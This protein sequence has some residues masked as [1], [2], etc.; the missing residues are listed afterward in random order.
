MRKNAWLLGFVLIMMLV[1]GACGGSAPEAP[2]STDLFVVVGNSAYSFTGNGNGDG[3][4]LDKFSKEN[5]VGI[6]VQVA[7][8]R[9]IR[10][11]RDKM[12]AGL[13]GAPDVLIVDDSLDIDGLQKIKMI[14]SHKVGAPI[15]SDVADSLGLQGNT[16][17]Y[18][19]FVSMV[20]ANNLSVVASSAMAGSASRE[21]FFSTMAWCA[22]MD[23][24][25]LTADI[26][27]MDY[28]QA[29]GKDVFDYIKSTNGANEALDLVYN[30]AISGEA[31]GSNTIIAFD[32][33]LLGAN[34]LNAKLANAGK[35]VFK[36]FYFREATAQ[37]NM[38]VGTR[39]FG[40]N[41]TKSLAADKLIE[42]MTSDSSQEAINLAGFTEGSAVLVRHNDTAFNAEWGVASNPANVQIVNAPISAVAGNALEVYRDYYKRMK[43]VKLPLDVSPSMFQN[44]LDVNV[45]GVSTQVLRIQALDMAMLKITNSGWLTEKKI[46]P[47]LKDRFDYYFFSTMYSGLVAQ[48]TGPETDVAGARL[49]YF[50]GPSTGNWNFDSY[51]Q[52]AYTELNGFQSNGTHIFDAATDMLNQIIAEYDPNVDY[53]IV[54]L[55]DGENDPVN[56]LQAD[57]FYNQWNSF[58][59]KNNVT[60]IGIQFGGDENSIAANCPFGCSSI[61]KAYTQQFGGDTYFGNNDA[62]LVEAFKR[63]IGR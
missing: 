51:G 16:I 41:E 9:D 58:Y 20:K 36:F 56:G 40:E 35:P 52:K 21:F 53:Y 2:A 7:N 30:A 60:V 50:I 4:L 11:F 63:I 17:S 8:D 13:D 59:G 43:V 14:A 49:D 12:L 26:V 10:D 47:G 38:A 44:S 48:T 57:D 39:D 32:S 24:A 3:L 45:N 27:K 42:Y 23:A 29:C 37:A 28:V 54:I 22:N 33:D 55:T 1:A 15:R 19:D 18:V 5:N 25:N 62:Q 34:G 6:F 46:L 61:G 31:T